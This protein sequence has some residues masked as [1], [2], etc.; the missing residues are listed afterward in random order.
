MIGIILILTS[1]VCGAIAT[2]LLRKQLLK[3]KP[4]IFPLSLMGLGILLSFLALKFGQVSYIYS[5]TG[6]TYVWSILLARK[7]LEEKVTPRQIIGIV[8]IILGCALLGLL[9]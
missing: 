4:I 7:Y 2:V 3:K 6:L 9:T 8:C 5:L 1:T